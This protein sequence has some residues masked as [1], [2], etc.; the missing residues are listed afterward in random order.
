[1]APPHPSLTTNHSPLTHLVRSFSKND[2]TGNRRQSPP[3]TSGPRPPSHLEHSASPNAR[4]DY[5]PTHFRCS[6]SRASPGS[7]LYCPAHAP[8]KC[9]LSI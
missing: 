8:C 3:Y 7:S 6:P 2:S 1:M 9:S 4:L 5:H